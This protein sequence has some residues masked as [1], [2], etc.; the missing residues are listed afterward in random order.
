MQLNELQKAWKNRPDGL[1]V[2]KAALLGDS[3]TQLLA[4]ALRGEAVRRGICLDLFEAEYGQV[5]R[6]LADLSSDLYA[7]DPAFVI[8]FQSSH[9]FAVAHAAAGP[10]EK[11]RMAGQRLAFIESVCANPALKGK[12][13]ICFNYPCLDDAVYGSYASKVASSLPAQI[14]ELNQGLTALSRNYPALFLCDLAAVQSRFGNDWLFDAPVYTSTEMVLSVDAL[15]VVAARVLDIISAVRGQVRKC[16]VLDLDN[17]LWGGV[18][19]DDGLEGI[20]LGHGLGI[21]KAFTEFQLWI[22]KMKERGIILCVASKNEEK[23]AKEPFLSHPEMVLHLEDIAVFKANW[24]TKVENIR[25][26]REI[27]NIGF[28][29]MVFLD[30]NPFEREMVRQGIPGITVPELPEDPACYVDFLSGLNLFETA[31]ASGED[32]DR[33]RQYQEEAARV[34][35]S[36]TFEDE[37]AYLASLGM[38]AE[39][40][41]FTA[42]NTPRVAQLTQRSNQFNLRTVRYTADE[43][44]TAGADP[45]RICLAL[46]LKDR[47][48]SS[49]LVVVVMLRR[50]DA[51]T[52]FIETW[53]MSCRVLKRG[54]E[55]FTL[56]TMVEAARSAGF[57]RIVGEYIPTA[58]NAMVR[59]L[60]PKLGF[61]PLPGT[62]PARYELDIADFRPLDVF[63]KK[64]ER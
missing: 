61:R 19:G 62:S 64:Q 49:G 39:V 23:T 6:Q 63:I 28:D 35:F 42:F 56:N 5:E 60:L 30:D 14:G 26:I 41:G 38:E 12:K 58:K 48:G 40:S 51:G 44:A 31:S 59:E 15:P 10:A 50:E 4:M 45:G 57:R 7:F 33:T 3:A 55:E 24:Q 53:L 22:K 1:P 32:L 43:I 18:I 11:E 8:V 16:L 25:T 54:M 37:A 13:I 46:S 52:C 34:S 2:V 21:G 17:T 47:F 20:Q 9:K 27:L 29:A 36:G